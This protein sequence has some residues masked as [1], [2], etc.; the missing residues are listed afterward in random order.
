M[1]YKNKIFYAYG[2]GSSHF[3]RWR[4]PTEQFI[5]L[6]FPLPS[7][8]E[9]RAIVEFLDRETGKID[10]LVAEQR[11]LMELLKEKRQAVISHAVTQGLNPHAP[12]KA[13]GIEWLGDVPEHWPVKAVR[14]IA[15]VVRGASPRPAGDSRYFGGDA[16]PW[17]TV[18]EITKDN[19]VDLTETETFLTDEGARNSRLFL[20]GTVIYSN[21]GAT[22]GVPK[23]LRIDGCANDGVVAFEK[24]SR[25]V[26]PH[27]LYQYLA[28]ITDVIRDEVKQGAG[29]PNLNTDIVKA[30]R[31]GI[32]PLDE[33]RE[34]VQRISELAKQFDTL[35][36]EAQR[37]IDL[38]QERRTALISA[39]VT[40]QIDVRGAGLFIWEARVKEGA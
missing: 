26:L 11:R 12:M 15:S 33:Q 28:S 6:R 37:A 10:E 30:L 19:L 8:P 7:I 36:V 32:P 2:Q 1:G 31:F 22:L 14:M 18:A 20:S 13:S 40:G 25:E 16:V 29:Q 39:A 38:L 9:Q 4:L 21:S 3:G 24:L 27:F 35:T 17:I 34:I 23:I 5:N